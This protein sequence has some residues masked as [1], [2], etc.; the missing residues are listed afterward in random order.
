MF[1]WCT[2]KVAAVIEGYWC[3]AIEHPFYIEMKTNDMREVLDIRIERLCS[4]LISLTADAAVT[5]PTRA[6]LRNPGF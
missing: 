1:F 5:R 2:Y 6:L 4:R 3:D